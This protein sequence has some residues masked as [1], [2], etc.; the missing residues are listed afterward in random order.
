MDQSTVM[1]LRQWRKLQIPATS[2]PNRLR[3]YQVLQGRSGRARAVRLVS[4]TLKT[5]QNTA[6][7]A[8]KCDGNTCS[9]GSCQQLALLG[10][11]MEGL[12]LGH[13]DTAEATT[14]DDDMTDLPSLFLN[15]LK[16]RERR[17][18]MQQET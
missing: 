8:A 7:R 2:R 17:Y 14:M 10:Y 12:S 3:K 13:I 4:P 16:P 9:S 1:R 6:K 15:C 5:K 11:W 18:A